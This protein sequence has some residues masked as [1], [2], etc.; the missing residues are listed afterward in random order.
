MQSAGFRELNLSLV[1]GSPDLQQSY[2]RPY[3]IDANDKF[4]SLIREARRLS[5]FITVYI[6][7]GLPGQSYAE[8][9]ETIDYLL[10]LDVLVGPSVFYLAPGSSLYDRLTLPP[11]V[12]EDWNVYRS[13]AFAVETPE[14]SR[15]QLLKLFSYVRQ[16]NLE[17]K[18]KHPNS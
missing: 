11:A 14:L 10:S 5:F 18:G 9:K 13:S 6:I 4:N 15:A 17:R 8:V 16:K 7:L 2:G 3:Q 1:T 12:K